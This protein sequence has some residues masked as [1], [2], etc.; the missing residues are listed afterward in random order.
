LITSSE[1]TF[2][3]V[4][5]DCVVD[6]CTTGTSYALT[7]PQ[8]NLYPYGN[9]AISVGD[10]PSVNYDTNAFATF[11]PLVTSLTAIETD[12]VT[13]WRNISFELP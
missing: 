9:V 1:D 10:V 11:N 7:H 8:V 2:F 3:G 12:T 4:I 5:K 13:S 6:G